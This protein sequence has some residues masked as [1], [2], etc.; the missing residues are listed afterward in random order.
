[1]VPSDGKSGGLAFLWKQYADVSVESYSNSHIDAVVLDPSTNKKW[2]A[3]GFYGHL[4][5]NQRHKSWQLLNTLY[6]RLNLPWVVFGDFNEIT[7]LEEKSGW[8]ERDAHQM[9]A[10]CN[11][12]ET[13]GLRDLG[14]I[15][16]RF[17]FCNGRHG[18]H[19]TLIRLNRIVANDQ[20]LELF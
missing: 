13:C 3:T 11:S 18:D 17:T 20:W 9:R 6:S 2:R 5:A 19:C 12:L 8:A 16:Q 7:H 4:D 15:G 1:M 10:F 14:F